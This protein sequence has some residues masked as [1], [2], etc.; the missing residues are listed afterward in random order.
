MA[1]VALL[2]LMAC[3]N[4]AGLLLARSAVRAPG[5]R[6]PPGYGREPRRIVRQLLTEGYCCS[7]PEASA[8]IL[9]THACLPLARAMP[10]DS[11]PRRRC[12]NRS[13]YTLRSTRGCWGSRSGITFLT[14]DPVRV[15]AGLAL[16][17]A[18]ADVATL[19]GPPD[20]HP[21]SCGRR[22]VVVAA[23]V[24][25][26][27]LILMGRGPARGD[28]R[29]H[30]FHESRLR[31]GT[32]CDLY[33]RS[34]SR[35]YT[36]EQSRALSKALLE[37]TAAATGSRCRGIAGASTDARYWREGHSFGAAGTRISR[38]GFPEQQP[39]RRHA[40]LLRHHGHAHP[41]WPRFRLVRPESNERRIR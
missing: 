35:G 11:R 5:D 12:C 31:P 3:A 16:R 29:A 20:H 26:C 13:P 30:A 1:G 8:G 24:A 21:A 17:C 39:E 22:L 32:R 18:R 15:V 14:A 10:A 34:R 25:I 9:L 36:S 6:H 27:T 4:V 2:L 7:R 37:K 19:C 33:D 41:G 40:R 23:Q 28:A 38:E